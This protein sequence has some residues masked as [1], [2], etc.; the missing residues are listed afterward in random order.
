MR[1][2]DT[3]TVREDDVKMAKVFLSAGHGG[4]DPGAVANGLRE[5]DINLQILLACKN[6]LERH[7]V[8]VICSRLSD[9]NDPVV[10]EVREANVSKADIAVSFHTNAGKGDGSETFYFSSNTCQYP[11]FAPPILCS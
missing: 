4:N 1:L 5:K 3:D 8:D 11:P 9:A 6:E 10:E 7:G 2:E